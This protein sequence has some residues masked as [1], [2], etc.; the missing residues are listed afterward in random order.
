MIEDIIKCRMCKIEKD[1]K[2]DYS[3]YGLIDK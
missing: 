1:S 2:I 3:T